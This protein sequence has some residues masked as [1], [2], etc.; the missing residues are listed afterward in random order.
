MFFSVKGEQVIR[1]KKNREPIHFP[2]FL[3]HL[4]ADLTVIGKLIRMRVILVLRQATRV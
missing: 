4:V 2:V 3:A 1:R